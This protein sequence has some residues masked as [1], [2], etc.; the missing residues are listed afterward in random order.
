MKRSIERGTGRQPGSFLLAFLLGL[1][2]LVPIAATATPQD[3]DQSDGHLRTQE[4][5]ATVDSPQ[6]AAEVAVSANDRGGETVAAFQIGPP[7]PPRDAAARRRRGSMVGYIEEAVVSSKVRVRFDTARHD[8]KPDRAEFFYAKCGCYAD[9]DH[10]HP[11]FD[12][13]APGP[14]PGAADDLNFQQLY[15]LGEY[16]AGER[17]SVF[18]EL[19]NRWIQPQSFIP[20]TGGSFPNQ[21]GIGDV[22]FGVKAALASTPEQVVTVRAQIFSPTGDAGSGLGTNHWSLEPAALYYQQLSD[23]VVVESQIGMWI[24]FGG[25]DGAPIESSDKFSG[26]VFFYG[27]GP[28]VEV[29]RGNRVRFAPIV[30][31][32]GWRVLSGFQSVGED[33]SGTNIFN[34]KIGART[35]FDPGH[36]IYI[37]YGHAMTDAAWYKDIVRFEYR[38]SF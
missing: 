24:P 35:S 34:I 18:G 21:S 23:R 29:Y 4:A 19:P 32:V 1:V 5:D 37:G 25:S 6:P 2:M 17:F 22:R 8:F 28:S 33:A 12:P 14:K 9:L 15:I 38:Y 36:S 27:I 11:L 30:E 31:F 16:A 7:L 26:R 10:S 20:E 3:A 13:N